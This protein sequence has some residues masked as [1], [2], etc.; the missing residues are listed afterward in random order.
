MFYNLTRGSIEC[1]TCD[2]AT[3][4][5]AARLLEQ[6]QV[7][8]NMVEAVDA[9]LYPSGAHLLRQRHGTA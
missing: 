1:P 8:A 2:G 9:A 7:V 6:F 4:V 5:T 3:G